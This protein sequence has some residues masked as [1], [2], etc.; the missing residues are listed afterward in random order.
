[1]FRITT[2]HFHLDIGV[3]PTQSTLLSFR[4]MVRVLISLQSESSH[5]LVFLAFLR[6]AYIRGIQCGIMSHLAPYA[7]RQRGSQGVQLNL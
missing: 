4:G 3:A 7:S 1:M 5:G 2:H 6:P